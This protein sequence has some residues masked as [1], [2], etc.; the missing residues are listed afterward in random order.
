VAAIGLA[1]IM[2]GATITRVRRRE[3]QLMVVDVVYLVLLTFVVWGRL[4][5]SP[6]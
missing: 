4:G 6:F 2:L 5:P 3:Y 1:V